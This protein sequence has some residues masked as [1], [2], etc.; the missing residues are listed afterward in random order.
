MVVGEGREGASRVVRNRDKAALNRLCDTSSGARK[1]P[2]GWG[3]TG[4]D[5]WHLDEPRVAHE[6]KTRVDP[7]LDKRRSPR[8]VSTP[9]LWHDRHLHQLH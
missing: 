4:R 9:S 8:I 3:D 5:R 2:R 7:R 6:T 1:E